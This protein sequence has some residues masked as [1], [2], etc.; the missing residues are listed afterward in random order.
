MA[1][2]EEMKI[3]YDIF[4]DIWKLFKKYYHADQSAEYWDNLLAESSALQA[5]YKST[6]CKDLILAVIDDSDR[7]SK[8]CSDGNLHSTK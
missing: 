6:L 5:K 3:E 8:T 1:T 7:R 4:G 2:N